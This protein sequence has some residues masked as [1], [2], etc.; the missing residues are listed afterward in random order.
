MLRG[1]SVVVLVVVGD[2]LG[3]EGFWGCGDED[4][5]MC[6]GGEKEEDDDD[7]EHPRRRCSKGTRRY[8]LA[9]VTYSGATETRFAKKIVQIARRGEIVSRMETRRGHRSLHVKSMARRRELR[10]MYGVVVVIS[11]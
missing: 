6:E 1:E 2:G 5:D 4:E 9:M 10:T 3:L 8:T 11:E 7:E